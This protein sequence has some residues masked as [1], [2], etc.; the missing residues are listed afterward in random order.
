M[1]FD[2][3]IVRTFLTLIPSV[4]APERLPTAQTVVFYVNTEAK[5]LTPRACFVRQRKKDNE[6]EF[7]EKSHLIIMFDLFLNFSTN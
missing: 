5:R 1:V 4:K 7:T 6:M 2:I 3:G